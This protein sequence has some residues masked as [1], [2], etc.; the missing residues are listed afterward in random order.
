M[1]M[2]RTLAVAVLC[3]GALGFDAGV[4]TPN[5]SVHALDGVIT[6]VN[7]LVNN[8][9]LSAVNLAKAKKVAEDVKADIEAVEGGK[10]SKQQAHEKVGAAMQELMSFQTQL[11]ASA[12]GASGKAAKLAN[13]EKELEAKKAELAKAE[14]ML[15]LMKLKKALAEKKLKLQ[16][17]IDQKNA[18]KKSGDEAQAEAAKTNE[19]VKALSTA[20]ADMKDS[21]KDSKAEL[22]T[23]LAKVH[24]RK[25]EVSASIASM[26][27]ME[28]KAEGEMESVIKAQMPGGAGQGD[29]K[30]KAMLKQLK[31]EEHRKF[32]KVEAVKKLQ[33][34]ELKDAE[35]SIEKHD[36]AALE[37]TL[38]KMEKDA[39]TLQSKS[40]KFLV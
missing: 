27:K 2:F 17:L 33:L 14:N 8:P 34:N 32:A 24:A 40:G 36:V 3:I 18:A 37:R 29:E 15:K 6:A 28:Q 31:A 21:K 39:K 1:A 38:D 25:E 12:T 35:A 5:D 16:K 20:V 9:H 11:T 22:K 26:E 10:L 19:V 23:V 7:S 4:W 13:L 30:A